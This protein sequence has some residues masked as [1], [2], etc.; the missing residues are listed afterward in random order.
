VS[1]FTGISRDSA[2]APPLPQP[3]L[4]MV[5]VPAPE[6]PKPDLV[7]FVLSFSLLLLTIT[8]RS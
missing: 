4:Q 2:S 7:R 3:T 5:S 6:A 8:S 1:S